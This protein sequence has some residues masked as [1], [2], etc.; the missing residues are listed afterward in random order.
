MENKYSFINEEQYTFFRK[1]RFVDQLI[2]EAKQDT[3]NNS[4]DDSQQFD[5]QLDLL[6]DSCEIFSECK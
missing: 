5:Y 3:T 6:N 4:L 2:E 1:N